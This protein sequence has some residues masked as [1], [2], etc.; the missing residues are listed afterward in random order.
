MYLTPL[1]VMK[2]ESESVC[3]LMDRRVLCMFSLFCISRW[4]FSFLSDTDL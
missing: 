2:L 1:V 3:T 4:P